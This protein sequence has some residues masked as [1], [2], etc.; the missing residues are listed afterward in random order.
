MTATTPLESVHKKGIFG[1]HHKKN[2]KDLM[3]ISE[4]KYLKIFQIVQYKKSNTQISTFNIEDLEFPK[5]P[6]EVKSN[7]NTRILWNGPRTWLIISD[8]ENIVDLI[9]KKFTEENFAVTDIS[10]SRAVIQ[11]KG[12]QAKEVLKKGCPINLNNFKVNHCAGTV[13]NG[14]TILVDFIDN[15]PDTYNLLTLRSFGESFYHHVADASLEYG[16]VGV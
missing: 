5:A 16:Y 9:K 7:K 1:D 14:I 2:E 15:N 12:L 11:V 10:H 3:R 4:L 8:K 13:F 6:L